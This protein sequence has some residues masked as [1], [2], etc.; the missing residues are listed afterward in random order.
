M[1]RMKDNGRERMRDGPIA[2]ALDSEI[3]V[4]KAKGHLNLI[5]S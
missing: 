2:T 4:F 5:D 1:L 3:R